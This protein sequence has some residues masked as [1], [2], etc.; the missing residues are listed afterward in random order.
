MG[1][2][3]FIFPFSPLWSEAQHPQ[4]LQATVPNLPYWFTSP[5]PQKMKYAGKHFSAP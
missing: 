1:G 2:Q 5:L 3:I 4:S